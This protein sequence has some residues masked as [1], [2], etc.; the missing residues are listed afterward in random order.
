MT[1]ASP[2]RD[3]NNRFVHQET[4]HLWWTPKVHYCVR[5]MQANLVHTLILKFQIN[6]HIHLP[7]SQITSIKILCTLPSPTCVLH[8][9]HMS[10]KAGRMKQA[11]HVSFAFLEQKINI[12]KEDTRN[13]NIRIKI[14]LS[15][16]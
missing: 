10:I 16:I 5:K 13:I 15:C 11:G 4:T 14:I 9:L 6:F 3:A 2:F 8:D 1:A 12:Q 7:I